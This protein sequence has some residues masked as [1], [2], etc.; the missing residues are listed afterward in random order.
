MF[1]SLDDTDYV[2]NHVYNY[3]REWLFNN[4]GKFYVKQE[5]NNPDIIC[6]PNKIIY[7]NKTLEFPTPYGQYYC[8][9]DETV[10]H[11]KIN[12]IYTTCYILDVCKCVLNMILDKEY[13]LT[14]EKLKKIPT[15]KN[16]LNDNCKFF[17]L[18]G[19][20]TDTL[21]EY[22]YCV[23]NNVYPI[24]CNKKQKE[25]VEKNE[26]GQSNSNLLKFKC[27]MLL[28]SGK[29]NKNIYEKFGEYNFFIKACVYV[30]KCLNNYK[31]FIHTLFNSYIYKPKVHNLDNFNLIGIRF[32]YPIS[33]NANAFNQ[34][35]V[36]FPKIKQ[37][38]IDNDNLVLMVDDKRFIKTFIQM[39]YDVLENKKITFLDYDVNDIY[40]MVTTYGKYNKFIHTWSGLYE[41]IEIYHQF[42]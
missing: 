27:N 26:V 13:N 10:R 29:I 36:M 17:Y 7:K 39:F 37:F 20:F 9:Y 21:K 18:D 24:A 35:N 42:K 14:I 15:N 40:E 33:N 5:Y 32:Y 19:G 12:N 23:N 22:Y 6:L 34:L 8:F 2:G 3:L 28:T 4:V 25:L 31:Q 11:E 16:R 38:I 41:L 30:S 1:I